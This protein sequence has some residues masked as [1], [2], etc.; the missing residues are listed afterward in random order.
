M[1][2]LTNVVLNRFSF[3]GD[4]THLVF[5]ETCVSCSNELSKEEKSICSICQSELIET[6]FHLAKEATVMDQL[7]WGR[8]EVCK[9]YSYLFFEKEKSSQHVLF[10]LKYR[11]NPAIGEYFGKEIAKRLLV[12]SEFTDVNAFIPAPLHPKKAFLRGYNQ[13]E[14]LAKGMSDALNIRLD[15]N[16]IIRAKHG[17]T[18][19]KKNR[20][21]RW[22]NVQSTFKTKKS[23]LHYNHVVLVDDVI[24]TGSTL[25]SIAQSIREVHPKIKISIVTLAMS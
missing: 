2:S 10:S 11:D 6:N 9:A 17:S 4:L 12:M 22:D 23:I 19:T 16:S 13:S 5:P 21:Q 1:N 15:T 8:F 18:Q 14:A 24:T 7:F 20:F 25:E 3:L